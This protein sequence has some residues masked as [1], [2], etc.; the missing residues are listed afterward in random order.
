[1]RCASS[2]IAGTYSI[3]SAVAC[4][5]DPMEIYYL[6][7]GDQIIGHTSRENSVM[8]AGSLHSQGKPGDVLVVMNNGW[9]LRY[10]WQKSTPDGRVAAWHSSPPSDD[11]RQRYRTLILLQNP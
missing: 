4:D 1:M 6:F 9:M 7:R 10:L 3:S 8:G 5:L 2:G 11:D